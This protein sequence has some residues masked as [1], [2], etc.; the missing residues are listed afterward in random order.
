MGRHFWTKHTGDEQDHKQLGCISRLINILDYHRW[1]SN[2]R[3]MSKHNKYAGHTGKNRK[4]SHEK[5]I[6]F[7]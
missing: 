3:N 6:C 5:R 1:H 4:H 7:A 2:T